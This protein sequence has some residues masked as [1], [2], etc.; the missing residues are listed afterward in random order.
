MDNGCP[1][2]RYSVYYR[3]I[4]QREPG[5]PLY[6]INITDVLTTHYVVSLRCDVQYVIEMSAWNELG[7]SDRSKTWIIKTISGRFSITATSVM[8]GVG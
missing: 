4:Q 7:E 6:E 3:Q 5:S 2:T 1:L 8:T